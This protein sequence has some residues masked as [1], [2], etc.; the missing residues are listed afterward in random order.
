[1]F[2]SGHFYREVST[3]SL[4]VALMQESTVHQLTRSQLFEDKQFDEA[5]YAKQVSGIL[6]TQH[7]ELIVTNNDALSV[8]PKLA[9]IYSEPFSDSSQIPTVL[10]SKMAK[11]RLPWLFQVTV[12]MNSSVAIIGTCFVIKCNNG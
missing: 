9:G 4:V 3:S 10:V 7:H 5:G 1:M 6:G 2:Q 12:G 11:K 8:V